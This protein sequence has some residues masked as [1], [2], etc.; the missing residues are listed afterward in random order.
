MSLKFGINALL[1][2]DK[3]QTNLIKD[4]NPEETSEIFKS[5]PKTNTAF[6]SKWPLGGRNS[7]DHSEENLANSPDTNESGNCEE[8]REPTSALNHQMLANIAQLE[9]AMMAAANTTPTNSSLNSFRQQPGWP[10]NNAL[11]SAIF[12][13][14]K[15]M[16]E[17]ILSCKSP[18]FTYY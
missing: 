7:E 18:F 15:T 13:Q 3:P 10:N 8:D 5:S 16:R 9:A 17:K 14:N 2:P 1:S 6:D 12:N 11:T 4:L